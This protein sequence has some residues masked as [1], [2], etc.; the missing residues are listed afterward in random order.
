[1]NLAHLKGRTAV[2]TGGSGVLCSGMA[3]ELASYGVRIVLLNRNPANGAAVADAIRQNGGEAYAI[4][5]DVLQEEQV[6]AA[7]R[8]VHSE[9]GGCDIL[10]NGAGGG[11]PSGNTTKERLEAGDHERTDITTMF[12][13]KPSGFGFVLDLNV[14]GTWVPTQHFTPLMMH[15]EGAIIINISSMAA[16]RPATKVPA[17]SA[18]KAAVENLTKWLAV[19]LADAGI[20]VNAIAPGFFVT[21]QNRNLLLHPDGSLTPRSEK[22]IGHTPMGRFGSPEDLLGTVRWLV[23]ERSSGFVTGITV[24][25]DGGFLAYSGV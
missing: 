22:I 13:M 24:P 7:A 19:H 3:M 17:Y 21:E 2:I 16:P 25:V 5:C 4:S 1:M 6:I 15:R 12:N 14:M 11:H 9:F 18:A 10:I 20:R 8:E 23:D